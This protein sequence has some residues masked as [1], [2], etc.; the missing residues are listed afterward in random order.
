MVDEIDSVW[1]V[2]KFRG[3][4]KNKDFL[5]HMNSRRRMNVEK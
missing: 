5:R 1:K 2:V 4:L 3:C